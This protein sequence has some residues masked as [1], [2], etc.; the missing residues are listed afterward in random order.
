M[1]YIEAWVS[2]SIRVAFD[3]DMFYNFVISFWVPLIDGKGSQWDIRF[4]EGYLSH[5]NRD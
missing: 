2:D 5:D 4:F 1:D 3:K